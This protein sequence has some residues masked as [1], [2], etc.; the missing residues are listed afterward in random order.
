MTSSHPRFKH[1]MN[2]R[3]VQKTDMNKIGYIKNPSMSMIFP[4]KQLL[5]RKGQQNMI[6]LFHK[7][8]CGKTDILS[9]VHNAMT[10]ITKKSFSL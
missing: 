2:I 7:D 1:N 6:L 5:F 9:S 8:W 4:C 3:P 10:Y